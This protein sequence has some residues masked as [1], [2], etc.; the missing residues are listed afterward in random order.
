MGLLMSALGGAA[1][2]GMSQMED[3]RKA[4]LQAERDLAQEESGKRLAQHNSDLAMKRS[5]ALEKMRQ[6]SVITEENRKLSPEYLGKVATAEETSYTLGAKTRQLKTTEELDVYRQKTEAQLTAEIAKL[7]NPKFIAGTKAFQQATRDTSNDGLRSVQLEA[8]KLALDEKKAEIKMP[9]AD[10]QAAESIKEQLKS[11]S[12]IIDKVTADG[13]GTPEGI[14]QLQ[15]E[16]A[17]LSK[18]LAKVYEPFRSAKSAAEPDSAKPQPTAQALEFL[19]KNPGQ[20]ANFVAKYGEAALPKPAKGLIDASPAPSKAPDT[21][22][23][24]GYKTLQ[25]AIDGA[26]QGNAGAINYLKT[27]PSGGITPQM[28]QQI[29]KILK[30]K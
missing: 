4:D 8:A 29:D 22:E 13:S 23:Y 9:Y 10:R 16:R 24:A 7:T 12:A 18:E 20:K 3:Q 17:A 14:A 30:G 19:A 25:G 28:R 27:M 2:V 15:L 1:E 5:E 6:E 21:F 26:A 11:K